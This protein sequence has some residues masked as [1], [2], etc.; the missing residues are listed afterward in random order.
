[1][2]CASWAATERRN[3]TT[4]TTPPIRSGKR[5]DLQYPSI[6]ITQGGGG[7]FADIWTPNT[8][9]QAGFYVSD[10]KTPGSCLR[11]FERAPCPQ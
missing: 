8:N 9:A 5:W 2:M 10:T 6:W 7:T 1:M 3:R 4:T 11:A